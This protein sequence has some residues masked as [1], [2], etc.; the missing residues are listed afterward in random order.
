MLL[1]FLVHLQLLGKGLRIPKAETECLERL[2]TNEITKS[3]LEICGPFLQR[4]SACT[5]IKA[6]Q[7]K[8]PL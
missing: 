3:K 1:I 8:C 6:D 5:L 2:Y 4:L 7:R